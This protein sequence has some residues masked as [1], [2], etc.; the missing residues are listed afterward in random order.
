MEN[1]AAAKRAARGAIRSARRL[2][3]APGSDSASGAGPGSDSSAADE[4]ATAALGRSADRVPELL[5]LLSPAAPR[6]LT[7]AAY[8]AAP[9][10]PNLRAAMHRWH[11]LGHRV[12]VPICAPGRQLDWVVWHPG[13]R[14]GPGALAP[15]PEPIGAAPAPAHN[16]EVVLVP[17]LS[18]GSDGTRLGQGGGY[19]DRFLAGHA[20]LHVGVVFDHE[21]VDSV[22]S[23]PWDAVLDAVWTPSSLRRLPLARG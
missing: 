3:H 10:E 16:A 5:S 14:V 13:I 19:Y 1:S 7:I 12:V 15:V 20:G 22:P 2:H 11:H 18:V 23:E 9:A 6:P 21:V 8:L 4:A 17:A